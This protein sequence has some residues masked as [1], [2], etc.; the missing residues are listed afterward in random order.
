MKKI[1]YGMLMLIGCL[2]LVTIPEMKA[3]AANES[4]AETTGYTGW[5][6][7]G[8]KKYYYINNEK[9]TKWQ[10]IQGRKYYFNKSGVMLTG[11]QKISKRWYQFGKNG[12]YTG[13]TKK[14]TIVLDPGHSGV[15]KGGTEPLGPGSSQRKSKDTSG[16]QGVATGVP[17]Y[18][19]NLTIAKKLKKELEKREYRVIL[20][21]KNHKKALSCIERAA[22]ANNAKADAYI[23]IHANGSSNRS[24]NGA[25][26]MCTTKNSP[27]VSKSLSK[28][29]KKLSTV[30]LDEYIKATKAKKEFV[31]ETD[32]MS[33]N[34]WSKVPATI[35]EMGYMTNPT[36]DKK[37][38]KAS[39]Q[40][41]IVTGIANGI[42]AYFE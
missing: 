24:T 17:E 38:Q 36:E 39:Y 2:I 40:K 33:G 21:R 20:T 10:T 27:Y 19:L 23:R 32:T 16:T 35:I 28:K 14:K 42:D 8:G 5:K 18:K 13:V 25:M 12:V 9:Q 22:I 30:L 37:M 6:K 29:S 34:N 4:Q 3:A 26:T 31:W 15:V 7:K 11:W 41:K 1:I